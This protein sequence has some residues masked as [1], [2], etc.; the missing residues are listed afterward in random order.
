MLDQ[1]SMSV[2]GPEAVAERDH[3]GPSLMLGQYS[4]G[5]HGRSDVNTL[6]SSPWGRTHP[7]EKV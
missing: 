6:G 4:D 1:Y 3:G 7:W 5:V 2:S